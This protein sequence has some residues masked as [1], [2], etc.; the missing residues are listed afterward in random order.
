[1]TPPPDLAAELCVGI[2]RRITQIASRWSEPDD[3]DGYIFHTYANVFEDM[4]LTLWMMGLAD[5]ADY[6]GKPWASYDPTDPFKPMP[7]MLAFHSEAAIRAGFASGLPPKTPP[8]DRLLAG[9]LELHCVFGAD[10]PGALSSER[11]PFAP[12][13]IAASEINALIR[14]GYLIGDGARV[15]WTSKVADA[16][17]Q[18]GEW[19]QDGKHADTEIW[20]WAERQADLALWMPDDIRAQVYGSIVPCCGLH[21]FA[22]GALDGPGLAG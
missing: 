8:L 12:P 3:P 18:I 4:G 20:A 9:Y 16:M 17:M 6:Q 22:S 2:A 14:H 15:A 1:M 11:R 5:A 19:T 10:L 21:R 13:P 7:P